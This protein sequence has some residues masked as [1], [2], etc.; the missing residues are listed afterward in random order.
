MSR[1]LYIF[2]VLFHPILTVGYVTVLLF[3]AYPVIT[4]QIGQS[5]NQLELALISIFSLTILLPL[6]SILVMK[7]LGFVQSFDMDNKEERVGPLI[8]S[9]IFYLWLFVNLRPVADLPPGLSTFILGVLIA[10]FISFFLNNFYK[11]SLHGVAAGGFSI[12][13]ILIRLNTD[14]SF[15][16]I[17]MKNFITYI[18]FDLVIMAVII[19]CGLI[20]TCR[21]AKQN[22]T[23]FQL[24]SGYATGSL[25]Q[26]LAWFYTS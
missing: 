12:G 11:I 20:G 14:I 24:Y 16:W 25:A 2:S 4:F 8:A 1:I 19:I 13:L 7:G 3:L 26:L 22:H 23:E 9:A 15:L 18:S 5:N 10:I 17:E 6:V 21:L